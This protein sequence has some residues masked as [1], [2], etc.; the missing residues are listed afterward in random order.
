MRGLTCRRKVVADIDGA[1]PLG[2]ETRI[3]GIDPNHAIER[4]RDRLGTGNDQLA[5]GIRGR[6][7]ADVSLA[8]LDFHLESL[9]AREM[10]DIVPLDEERAHPIRARLETATFQFLDFDR[11]LVAV[12]HDNSICLLSPGGRRPPERHHAGNEAQ[13]LNPFLLSEAQTLTER[14]G[15]GGAVEFQQGNAE[16]LPFTDNSFDIVLSVTVI[17]ECDADKAISEMVRVVRPGGRVA[18]KVRACDMPVFWN[19]PLDPEIKAKAERP[20]QQVAPSG[21]ADASL[22]QRFRAAGLEDVVAYPS[23]HGSQALRDYYEPMALSHLNDEEKA[24]WHAAKATAL[25]DGTFYMM[26]PAHCAIGTKP[27]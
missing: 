9:R 1:V 23:F 15:L 4:Q 19:L 27:Q 22:M 7:R 12:F 8:R 2:P 17:E 16:A 18:V 11:D 25:A 13:S 20:I 10:V 24:A 5:C 14:E 6:Q 26:H 3:G 21:C